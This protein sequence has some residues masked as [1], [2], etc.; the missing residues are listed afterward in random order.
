MTG[1][2]TILPS[3]PA[4][5]IKIRKTVL[6]EDGKTY[7]VEEEIAIPYPDKSKEKNDHGD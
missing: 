7:E 4:L 1:K 3:K 6:G 2:D 5:K